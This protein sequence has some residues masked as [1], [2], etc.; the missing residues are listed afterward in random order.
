MQHPFDGIIIPEIQVPEST[1]TGGMP[2]AEP[3][4]AD[5]SRRSVLRWLLAVAAGVFGLYGKLA[6]A[7]TPEAKKSAPPTQKYLLFYVVPKDMG[8]FTS[9]R[10][11]ELDVLGNQQTGLPGAKELAHTEGFLAWLTSEEADKLRTQSDINILHEIKPEEKSNATGP[12]TGPTA[13]VVSLVPNEWSPRPKA[14]TYTGVAG[15]A[16]QWASEFAQYK[17]VKVSVMEQDSKIILNFGAGEIP[18]KVLDVVKANPQVPSLQWQQSATTLAIG[19]EGSAT[20]QQAREE[21]GGS[22]G[23]PTT[24]AVGEEGGQPTT[25]AVGEEGGGMT[26]MALGEEGTVRPP[27][28]AAPREEGRPPPGTI[29]TNIAGEEGGRSSPPKPTTLMVGEEGG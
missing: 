10:R 6:R 28:T 1:N 5:A 23:T 12:K 25:L 22:P 26:T 7:A 18:E 2:I 21:G 20:T 11:K 17:N 19:E 9:Q 3:A 24:R 4:P 14:G 13:L 27:L 15:L 16:K 29:T 8:K